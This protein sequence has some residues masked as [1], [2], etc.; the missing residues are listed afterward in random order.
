MGVDGI[1]VTTTVVI[2][3]F[4][5]FLIYTAFQDPKLRAII[6]VN[7][8][9]IATKQAQANYSKKPSNCLLDK[10]LEIRDNC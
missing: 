1:A 6:Y 9:I 7:W 3:T 8:P 10:L 4:A 5:I 2:T